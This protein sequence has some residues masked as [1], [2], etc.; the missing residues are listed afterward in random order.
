VV[1]HPHNTSSAEPPAAHLQRLFRA[2]V[3]VRLEGALQQPAR[4]QRAVRRRHH[5]LLYQRQ[6]G[7][8][9]GHP[10]LP[11]G[12][13]VGSGRRQA[14]HQ[15]QPPPGL[16]RV[17]PGAQADG[18]VAAATP[19]ARPLGPLQ[20]QQQQQRLRPVLGEG[21]ALRVARGAVCVQRRHH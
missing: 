10:L 15:V 16:V 9:A 1:Y 17:G 21:V 8:R 3:G 18:F 4:L 14:C 12:R 20:A 7:G 11:P 13:R 5:A 6:P 2:A 19:R